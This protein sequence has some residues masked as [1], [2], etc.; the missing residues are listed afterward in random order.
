[1]TNAEIIFTHSVKLLEDGVIK[2]TGEFYEIEN[3][4]GSR[5]R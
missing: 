5:E 3:E 1:M 2:G 4:D